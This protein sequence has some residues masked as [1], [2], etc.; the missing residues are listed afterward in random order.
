[1]KRN[2]FQERDEGG[3]IIIRSFNDAVLAS[4]IT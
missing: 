4:E 3:L 2:R 1:M